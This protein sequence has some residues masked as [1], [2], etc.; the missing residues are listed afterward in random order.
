MA[1]GRVLGRIP[2]LEKG[3]LKS[4]ARTDENIFLNWVL[5]VF[6]MLPLPPLDGGAVLAGL[7][8]DKHANVLQFLEQYG[9]IILI[10]LLVTGVLGY[11]LIPAAYVAG[12]FIRLAIGAA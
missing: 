4:Q 3:V 11:L 10:G 9:F 6:N 5:A 7:L 12:F 8:P 2:E 1:D